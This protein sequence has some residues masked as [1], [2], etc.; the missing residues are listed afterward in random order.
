MGLPPKHIIDGSTRKKL[1]FDSNSQ[2]RVVPNSRGKKRKPASKTLSQVLKCND[3]Y[4]H[5]TFPLPSPTCINV[6]FQRLFLDFLEGCLKW[7]AKERMTPEEGLKH[8]W[9]LEALTQPV[10]GT[11]SSSTGTSGT[12]STTANGVGSSSSVY[13]SGSTPR[14]VQPT[15]SLQPQPPTSARIVPKR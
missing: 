15:Q 7:D 3:K 9:I 13:G 8:A 1:F 10:A 4:A 12:T 11:S 5:L 6:E 14:S 2:A